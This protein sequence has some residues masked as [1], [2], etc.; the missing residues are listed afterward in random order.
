[1]GGIGVGSDSCCVKGLRDVN[2]KL[3]KNE[4]TM[5]VIGILLGLGFSKT[6]IAALFH[7]GL[8]T[9]EFKVDDWERS[10]RDLDLMSEDLAIDDALEAL[11]F[12]WNRAKEFLAAVKVDASE[13][14]E[15][16]SDAKKV[17]LKIDIV[18]KA[19]RLQL[20]LEEKLDDQYEKLI[21]RRMFVAFWRAI[22][23]KIKDLDYWYREQVG[24]L[25]IHLEDTGQ[26]PV[27]YKSLFREW[28][29]IMHQ[30]KS[31]SQLDGMVF[32]TI[33]GKVIK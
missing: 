18:D 16:E 32:G 25:N 15:S 29:K 12:K 33:E 30:E 14:I 28:K 7:V 20:E 19:A 6:D 3:S 11:K 26:S 13:V 9:V 10:D 27:K 8:N 24:S 2:P 21:N 1:V 5:G 4:L 22:N 23:Q 17:K 31:L